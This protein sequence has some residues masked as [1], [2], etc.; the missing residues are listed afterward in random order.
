M[1][2]NMVKGAFTLRDAVS[3]DFPSRMY[4]ASHRVVGQMVK[5]VERTGK[6]AK[7]LYRVWFHADDDEAA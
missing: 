5:T 4:D 6:V 7:S 1:A 3:E 2:D